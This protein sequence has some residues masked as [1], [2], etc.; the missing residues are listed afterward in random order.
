LFD[1]V[2]E[3][4]LHMQETNGA[5]PHALRLVPG[6]LYEIMMNLSP[7]EVMNRTK[8]VIHAVHAHHVEVRCADGRVLPVPR[9]CRGVG[10]GGTCCTGCQR[11]GG[12]GCF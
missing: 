10:G 11:G 2:S 4:F 12:G 5:P 7:Q 9:I 3:E 8:V 1:E 6:A